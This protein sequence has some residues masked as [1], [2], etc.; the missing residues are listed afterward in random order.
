MEHLTEMIKK[1]SSILLTALFSFIS[2][3]PLSA[4]QLP[5]EL[6]TPEKPV[7]YQNIYDPDNWDQLVIYSKT[8]PG[9]YS[10]AI[11]KNADS[12]AFNAKYGV[13]DFIAKVQYDVSFNGGQWQYKTSWDRNEG[14]FGIYDKPQAFDIP[15]SIIAAHTFYESYYE[16]LQEKMKD[17]P[18]FI[19]KGKNGSSHFNLKDNTI[20]IRC[21]YIIGWQDRE[22]EWHYLTGPWSETG[23]IGRDADPFSLPEFEGEL[24]PPMI[25][26]LRF[27]DSDVSYM[28]E[29]DPKTYDIMLLSYFDKGVKMGEQEVQYRKNGGEWHEAGIG[30]PDWIFDGRRSFTAE[31]LFDG[32]TLDVRVRY[33]YYTGDEEKFTSW[34]EITTGEAGPVS[35]EEAVQ[36]GADGGDVTA[37]KVRTANKCL[38]GFTLCCM[39]WH[40]ISACVWIIAALLLLIVLYALIKSATRKNN[41]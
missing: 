20:A 23:H 30:N 4:E 1:I 5:I 19:F 6:E 41:E 10:L 35:E 38:F 12:N 34:S 9:I 2:A 16:P 13:N 11:E 27:V 14:D 32:D 24:P 21:R 18:G 15:N 25:S 3:F 37:A 22:D 8:Q 31:G 28:L 36:E 26:S 7:Y 29:S 17:I 39:M 33:S 40:G